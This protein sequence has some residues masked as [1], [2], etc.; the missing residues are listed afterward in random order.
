MFGDSYFFLLAELGF[1]VVSCNVVWPLIH[2]LPFSKR[3]LPKAGHEWPSN[4]CSATS[5]P[6]AS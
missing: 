1:A 4:K 6:C 5:F 3:G 2:S